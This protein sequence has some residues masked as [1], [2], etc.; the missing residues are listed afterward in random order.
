MPVEPLTP[1][2]PRPVTRPG[3]TQVWRDVTMLH[4]A[5][6]PDLVA[7]LLPPGTTVDVH[8]GATYVGLVPFVMESVRVLGTPPVPWVARFPETNVRLYAVD[9]DGRRGVVFR[10]LEAARLLP[11]LVARAAYRLPYT[12]A[13]MAT[14]RDGAGRAY[15]TS[16]RWPGPAGAGG[17][18]QVETG[19]PLDD[20]PLAT[21]LTARWGLYSGWRGGRTAW[22]P[23]EHP[24]WPLHA[25][26]LVALRD[27]LVRTAVW[28]CPGRPAPCSGRR[29]CPCA[30]GARGCS[31]PPPGSGARAREEGVRD[32]R[33]PQ[34]TAAPV[35]LRRR[36][37][38]DR[39]TGAAGARRPGDPAQPAGRRG[40]QHGRRHAAHAAAGP[41][42]APPPPTP[43][44]RRPAA[45]TQ[46]PVPTADDER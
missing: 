36:H 19:P 3:M 35:V 28:P 5:V 23:V 15:T 1:S 17:T 18:V 9:H 25:A 39:R 34:R 20:D 11:V 44:A 29:A 45:A 12:W 21:F 6:D 22:A 27:D 24:P 10:S 13:R 2:P 14:R 26:R 30:W 4:W 43:L 33:L 42:A 41:V 40:A 16:R 38:P 7:P 31:R 46:W 37:P 8:E 32:L